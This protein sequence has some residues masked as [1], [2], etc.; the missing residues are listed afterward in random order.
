MI[1]TF[2]S[3]ALRGNVEINLERARGYTRDCM[4]RGEVPVVPNF[5]AE[6]LDMTNEAEVELGWQI[7]VEMLPMADKFRQVVVDG[8]VSTGMQ[9]EL[10][11]WHAHRPDS[12]PEILHVKA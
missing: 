11:W 2:V 6:V 12:P 5:L 9:W 4:L 1:R 7:A 3:C 10:D 8:Y